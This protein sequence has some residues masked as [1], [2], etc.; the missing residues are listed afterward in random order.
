MSLGERILIGSYYCS[1][2]T[3]IT[4]LGLFMFC[5]L[6]SRTSIQKT[7]VG[8]FIRDCSSIIFLIH[9]AVKDLLMAFGIINRGTSWRGVA[10]VIL[11][12]ILIAAGYS[13]YMIKR[14]KSR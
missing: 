2:G 13:V 12:S 5:I 11:I 7:M 10:L 4:A 14:G 6:G 3:A 8:N 1:I 9:I